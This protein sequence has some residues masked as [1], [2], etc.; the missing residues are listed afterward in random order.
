[1]F[2]VKL[3]LTSVRNVV[4]LEDSTFFVT[5]TFATQQIYATG[6]NSYGKLCLGD[7][8]NR[9][10]YTRI[11]GLSNV[12]QIVGGVSHSLFLLHNSSVLACG[13]NQNGE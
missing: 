5:G 3:N 8:L 6:N 12:S 9:Y 13:S 7:N 2:P 10:S 1:M 4:L 11:N